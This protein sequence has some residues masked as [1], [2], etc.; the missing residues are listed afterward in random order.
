MVERGRGAERERENGR[1]MKRER[2]NGRVE[3]ERAS[4]RGGG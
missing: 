3:K 4:R 2:E 1:R